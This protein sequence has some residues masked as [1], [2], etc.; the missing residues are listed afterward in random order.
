MERRRKKS[1]DHEK[2]EQ[3]IETAIDNPATFP[4][5]VSAFEDFMSPSPPNVLAQSQQILSSLST[6][7]TQ[8]LLESTGGLVR[9]PYPAPAP[10]NAPR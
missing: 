9:P 8:Q 3:E 7:V 4:A 2:L 5:M 6:Y 1:E 10:S